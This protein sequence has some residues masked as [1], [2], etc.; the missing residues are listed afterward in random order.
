M[1][2]VSV[3]AL[4]GN[5]TVDGDDAWAALATVWCARSSDGTSS[6]ENWPQLMASTL[7][8]STLRQSFVPQSLP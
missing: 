2:G 3:R 4:K 7:P 1:P 6:M 8:W 5:D